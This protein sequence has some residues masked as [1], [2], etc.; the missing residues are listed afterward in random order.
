VEVLIQF[1]AVF[2]NRFANYAPMALL[3]KVELTLT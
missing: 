3:Y 1:A 2:I